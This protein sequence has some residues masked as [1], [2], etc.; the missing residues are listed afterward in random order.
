MEYKDTLQYQLDELHKAIQVVKDEL[1]KK[2]EP[3][4]RWVVKITNLV[5]NK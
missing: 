2:I 4:I 5:L 1:N 3:K